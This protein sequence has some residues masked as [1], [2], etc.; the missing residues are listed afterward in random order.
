ME[1][2]EFRKL[3]IT[4]GWRVWWSMKGEN[5]RMGLMNQTQKDQVKIGGVVDRRICDSVILD[6]Y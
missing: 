4:G 1:K 6:D 5:M 3:E 2:K